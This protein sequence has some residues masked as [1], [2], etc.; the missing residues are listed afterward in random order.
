[1]KRRFLAALLAVF[2]LVGTIPAMGEPEPVEAESQAVIGV[3]GAEAEGDEG[4]P[5]DAEDEGEADIAYVEAQPDDAEAIPS[6]DGVE[7]GDAEVILSE[8]DG[9][10]EASDD[11]GAVA[12]EEEAQAETDAEETAEE[13]EV[14]LA[15][16]IGAEE[17]VEA[18]EE[19]PEPQDPPE[20]FESG[21]LVAP[22]GAEVS[23]NGLN[24]C[25]ASITRS[26]YDRYTGNAGDSY[27][28]NL[29]GQGLPCPYTD[30]PYYRNGNVGTDG[31]VYSNGFEVWLARW[32][33]TAEA[34]W[35]SAVYPLGGKYNKLTG[36][37]G[38]INSYNTTDFDTTVCFYEHDTDRLLTTVHMTPGSNRFTF[39][40]D[41]SG[42]QNLRVY[43]RDNKK[44]KGGTSYALYNLFLTIDSAKIPID[45]DNFPDP[46]F[47][48]YVTDQIA[49]GDPWLDITAANMVTRIDVSYMEYA[50][51]EPITSLSGISVFK[52]LQWLDCSWNQIRS[53]DLSKNTKLLEVYCYHQYY[54]L[55]SLKLGTNTNLKILECFDNVIGRLDISGCPKLVR[56][57]KSGSRTFHEKYYSYSYSTCSLKI[58]HG[59][60]V[61]ATKAPVLTTKKV[62]IGVGEKF[63][64]IASSSPVAAS[65]CKYKVS[66]YGYAKV[67]SKGVVTGKKAG[68][69]VTITVKGN[70]KTVT[71]KVTVKKAPGRIRLSPTQKTLKRGKSFQLKKILPSGTA[72]HKITYTSDNPKV[73]KV[74]KSGKVT[75]VAPGTARITVKTFNGRKAK[76]KVTVPRMYRALIV[77]QQYEATPYKKLPGNFTGGES[78][79]KM[80]LS[81]KQ[82]YTTSSVKLLKDATSDQIKSGVTSAFS[83]ALDGD[84][85]LFWYMGHG[86]GPDSD[87]DSVRGALVTTDGLVTVRELA[88]LL[89]NVKGTKIVIMDCC[90]SGAGIYSGNGVSS[91]SAAAFDDAVLRAFAGSGSGISANTGELLRLNNTYV[92]TAAQW[93]SIGFA[94]M[95]PGSKLIMNALT[96]AILLGMGVQPANG[97]Y[98]G[99]MPAD[100]NKDR[101]LTLGE[102]HA[103][104]TTLTRR[105]VDQI[106]P[107]MSG[108]SSYVM[109]SR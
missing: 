62:T 84:V 19:A 7:I 82:K 96:Q 72:S 73:A 22:N 99:S 14:S 17:P 102:L 24:K 23:G 91:N 70:G 109:F 44:V 107:Q 92:L 85:S 71:C 28:Y 105:V 69:T 106:H 64:L 66:P 50:Y 37:T 57:Y 103:Y 51:G 26:S 55:T 89:K 101:K 33:G 9:A 86:Q 78:V 60:K 90:F 88:D 63:S 100:K 32:N 2:M 79:R 68:K 67:S 21:V 20:S 45:A 4:Q 12:I 53:L 76:C 6:E 38:L 46:V 77:S 49:D 16:L 30:N 36:S 40:V 18:A 108:K 58:D 48:A 95:F 97:A 34:S 35:V 87:D 15:E 94:T 31:T 5:G 98:K 81:L 65:K 29:D 8:E 59:Q 75:A 11:E 10:G 41:V 56:A 1:M 74:S 13:L 104:A 42:V 61:T 27:I 43:V 52:N 54:S 25:L 47:R 93:D 39:S 3:L 80:L 83:G